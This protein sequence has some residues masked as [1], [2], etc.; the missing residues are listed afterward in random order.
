MAN[1]RDLKALL[2]IGIATM[3]IGGVG[4]YLGF[5]AG[6]G[7]NHGPP[8]P[9]PPD[10]GPIVY[11]LRSIRSDPNR[12]QLLWS[13]VAGA[14]GYEVTVMSAA[15]ESLFTSPPIRTTMWTIPPDL[16]SRLSPQTAYHWRLT[17]RL[18]GGRVDRSEPAAFATE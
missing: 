11:N 13:P 12:V 3:V 7:Q 6:P 5:R 18:D 2:W 17:V 1:G 10:R 8:V 9:T 16:A 4:L 14:Q 15:D